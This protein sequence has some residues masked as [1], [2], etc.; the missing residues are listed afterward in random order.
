MYKFDPQYDV[1]MRELVFPKNNKNKFNDGN[2]VY[3]INDNYKYNI[4]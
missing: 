1:E 4:I 2:M 3:V